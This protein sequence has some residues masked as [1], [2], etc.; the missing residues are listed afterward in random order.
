MNPI[1]FLPTP[2]RRAPKE[3][4]DEQLRSFIARAAAGDVAAFESLYE[5]SSP[6]LLALVRRMVGPDYA[7]D[8]L[9]E[10]FLQVWR[11][12]PSYESARGEPMLWL[13]IIA[14]T[15][16]LDWLRRERPRIRCEVNLDDV[17]LQDFAHSRPEDALA[18]SQ[19]CARVHHAFGMLLNSNERMVLALVFFRDCTCTE[20]AKMTGMPLGTVKS[21]VRRAQAKL[22]LHFTQGAPI[23]AAGVATAARAH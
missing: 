18:A 12:L 20:I 22:R 1:A 5:A 13:S 23:A 9:T 17:E 16:A 19:E 6:R 21:L 10:V 3:G 2:E 4:Y 7:E 8:V 15:R 14:R 11:Q